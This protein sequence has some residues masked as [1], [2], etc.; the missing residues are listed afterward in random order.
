MGEKGKEREKS[1][2]QNGKKRW[3]SRV[4]DVAL[5]KRDDKSRDVFQVQF[6]DRNASFLFF[7]VYI[8]VVE[9]ERMNRS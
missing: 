8:D 3:A 4:W 9:L 1:I 5:V 6:F 2:Q 7:F